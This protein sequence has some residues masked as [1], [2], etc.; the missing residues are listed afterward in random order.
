MLPKIKNQPA[1][2]AAETY[3][4]EG[5]IVFTSVIQVRMDQGLVV[6]IRCPMSS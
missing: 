3:D 4:Q 2:S 5:I 1:F 6:K